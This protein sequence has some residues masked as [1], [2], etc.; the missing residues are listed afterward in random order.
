MIAAIIGGWAIVPWKILSSAQ[1]F[2][3]F[4]SG[5]AVF[6]APIAGILACDYWLVKKQHIDIPALYNPDGRYRYWNGINWRALTALVI[7]VTPNL[8]GL[9]YSIALVTDP[10]TGAFISD[11]VHISSGAKNLYTFDWLFGF[12][13]SIFVYGVLSLVWPAKESLVEHTVYGDV[14]TS[15]SRSDEESG[16]MSVEVKKREGAKKGFGNLDA[17]DGQVHHR[18]L[19]MNM[20]Q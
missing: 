13:T 4:M 17:V 11:S 16:E 10:I 12:T 2:L 1:T 9:G 15:E 19:E 5:Y 7:A 8:P 20:T 18:V 3:A 6:L 14:V